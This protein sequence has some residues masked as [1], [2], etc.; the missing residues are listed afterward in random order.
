LSYA[1]SSLQ[2][3]DMTGFPAPSTSLSLALRLA[4]S[5]AFSKKSNRL[6]IQIAD[7]PRGL[8]LRETNL[9]EKV[10]NL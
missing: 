7:N 6:R 10:G 4:V 8:S 9:I 2:W 3:L 5:K 1:S